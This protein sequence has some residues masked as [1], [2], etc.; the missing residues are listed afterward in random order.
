MHN[1]DLVAYGNIDDNVYPTLWMREI[2]H[3]IMC[4]YLFVGLIFVVCQ[5]TTKIGPLENFPIMVP[6]SG[7]FSR[8][9][10]LAV[11]KIYQECISKSM[12][13]TL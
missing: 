6:Y 4:M 3:A 5:S 11:G 12:Q 2:V 10:I 1:Y 8:G 13:H 9:P 7:K